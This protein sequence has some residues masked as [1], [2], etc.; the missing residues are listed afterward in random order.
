MWAAPGGTVRPRRFPVPHP[1]SNLT[2]TQAA[3]TVLLAALLTAALVA[4]WVVSRRTTAAA[5][6]L[7]P[8]PAPARPAAAGRT[9]APVGSAG[10]LAA[11]CHGGPATDALA[12]RVGP[13]TWRASGACWVA[14]DPHTAAYSLLTDRP[15]RPVRVTAAHIMERYAPGTKATDD[16]RC[17]ACHTNPVLAAKGHWAD[18]RA[19]AL[20]AEGVSCEACHGSAGGWQEVHYGAKWRA[21]APASYAAHGM[22]PLFDVG[23]RALE[24][25]G[26]H[27]GAP[28]RREGDTEVVPVRDMNHDMIAAGHPRLS[29]DFADYLNRLPQ[30]WQEKDRTQKGVSHPPARPLNAAKAWLVGRA[31]HAGAACELLADRVARADTGD[32]RTPWPEYAEFNCAACHHSLRHPA[33][34][35][36]GDWRQKDSATSGRGLGVAAWQAVWPL[37]SATGLAV[38]TRAGA[39]LADVALAAEARPS[40]AAGPKAAAAAARVAELRAKWLALPDA[41][42]E[43]ELAALVAKAGLPLVPEWDAAAQL[44]YARAALAR[45]RHPSQAGTRFDVVLDALRPKRGRPW[46][47][48]DWD[49]VT[50]GFGGRA[51]KAP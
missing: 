51:P 24:C 8:D 35:K 14:A 50:D 46:P 27:V 6:E 1:L 28:A 44:F 13:D 23:V 36:S 9:G 22:T 18:P 47:D 10:C 7:K 3:R 48:F 16:A 15:G 42:A 33:F 41:A 38:P 39:P 32:A 43:D 11:A 19:V 37:T 17:V 4:A 31:A 34:A 40:R 45:A 12:G 30:H 29:F 2:M 26:C 5:V 49:T 20:R 25:A 21:D